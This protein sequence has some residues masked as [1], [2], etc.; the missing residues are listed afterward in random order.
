MKTLKKKIKL[1]LSNEEEGESLYNKL[2]EN[3]EQFQ[4]DFNDVEIIIEFYSTFYPNSKEELI[5]S[6]KE[7]HIEYKEK[8]ND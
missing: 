5:R 3:Y 8:K 2:K 7:K 1:I 4:K 6:I